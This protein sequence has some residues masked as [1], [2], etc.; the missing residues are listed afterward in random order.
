MQLYVKLQ[1]WVSTESFLIKGYKC[2][3][4]M[5]DNFWSNFFYENQR[6]LLHGKKSKNNSETFEK[7]QKFIKCHNL[8]IIFCKN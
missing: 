2:L 7:Q 3:S 6:R 8:N 5:K 1:S 4:S